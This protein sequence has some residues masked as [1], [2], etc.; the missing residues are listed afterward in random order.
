MLNI[1]DLL[2]ICFHKLLTITWFI[3]K[4]L[5]LLGYSA[6]Q[7]HQ[8][9]KRDMIWSGVYMHWGIDQN[10]YVTSAYYCQHRDLPSV[11]CCNAHYCVALSEWCND[12]CLRLFW[13]SDEKQPSTWHWS[14]WWYVNMMP[15]LYCLFLVFF[16]WSYLVVLSTF[17]YGNILQSNFISSAFSNQQFLL[18]VSV[19]VYLCSSASQNLFHL[20]KAIWMSAYMN[21]QWDWWK[22]TSFSLMW[23]PARWRKLKHFII[24]RSSKRRYTSLDKFKNNENTP[25]GSSYAMWHY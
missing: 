1:D 15:N 18:C 7:F 14:Q 24:R 9:F 2:W 20:Q 11:Q 5:C 6:C 12:A 25:M 23:I 19:F 21:I 16:P 10:S 17:R 4:F 8:L 22:A 3:K 13:S